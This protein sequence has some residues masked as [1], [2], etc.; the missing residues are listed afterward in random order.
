MKPYQS[1]L[2]AWVLVCSAAAVPARASS[3]SALYAFGDSLSDVG[4]AYSFTD[5]AAPA[6]PY[7]AG[8]FSNGPIW[9]DDVAATLGIAPLQPSL[10]GGTDYA[11][12]GAVTGTTPAATAGLGDLPWQI[13]AFATQHPAAD[14]HAL[15]TVWAGANDLLTALS[16]G[17]P[18]IA[19]GTAEAAAANVAAAV[20]KLASLGARNLLVADVPDLGVTP[21]IAGSALAGDATSLTATFNADL[22][23]D[24]L[25]VAATPGID[26]HFLDTFGPLDAIVA[27]PAA[28]G[29]ANVTDPCWTGDVYGYAAGGV[30]C[31][32]TTSGQNAY[33]F[34]DNLHPTAA[35]QAVT[36]ADALAALP[37]PSSAPVLAGGLLGLGLLRRRALVEKARAKG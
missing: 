2:A 33:L 22:L 17:S 5:G 29:F 34:W 25:P 1:R 35:G 30:L 15:Y 4:N 7:F 11:V 13:A 12:G 28:Y 24:L 37:E 26:L 14:P 10:L 3:Y 19:L 9:L 6:P 16:I 32:S 27:N 18:T 20:A 8:R 23:T 21:R 31:A 36:A